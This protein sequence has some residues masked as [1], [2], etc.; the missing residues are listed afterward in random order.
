MQLLLSVPKRRFKH[1]VDRNR[2]KRQLREAFRRNKRLLIEHMPADKA[3]D[4]AFVW[5]SS[6]HLS[7]K[8]VEERVSSLLKQIAQKL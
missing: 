8:M 7:T 3:V 4:I 6:N 2:I 5:L 1:A